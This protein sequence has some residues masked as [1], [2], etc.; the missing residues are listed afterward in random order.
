MERKRE[1]EI[2]ILHASGTLGSHRG[3][4]PLKL[5]GNNTPDALLRRTCP[6]EGTLL[7][8]SSGKPHPGALVFQKRGKMVVALL[9]DLAIY[10]YTLLACEKRAC[11]GS[12]NVLSSCHQASL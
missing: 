3:N 4:I 2:M 10:L 9:A 6:L 7:R 1:R 8:P 5:L 11:S 12:L